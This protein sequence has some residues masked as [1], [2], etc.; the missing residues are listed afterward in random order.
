M[1]IN[2]DIKFKDAN[3]RPKMTLNLRHYIV[4]T[5]T[6][7][8]WSDLIRT[9]IILQLCKMQEINILGYTKNKIR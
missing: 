4:H 2:V 6:L 7:S 9:S 5:L 1:L 3:I 8:Q